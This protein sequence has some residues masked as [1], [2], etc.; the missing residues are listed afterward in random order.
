MRAFP[1]DA[2]LFHLLRRNAPGEPGRWIELAEEDKKFNADHCVVG[3]IVARHWNLPDFI[4]DAIRGY[5]HDIN[6]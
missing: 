1:P 5:H 3:Y 6:S 4:A 2:A